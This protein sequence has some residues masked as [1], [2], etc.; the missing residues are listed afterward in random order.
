MSLQRNKLDL[1]A[2]D[3]AALSF[4]LIENVAFEQ[5]NLHRNDVRFAIVTRRIK[6]ISRMTKF[7]CRFFRSLMIPNKRLTVVD[8]WL[9]PRTLVTSSLRENALSLFLTRGSRSV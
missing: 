2:H 1:N 7:S 6:H 3:S 9:T 4:V 5:K 8:K